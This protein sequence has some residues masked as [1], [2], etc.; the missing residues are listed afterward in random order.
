MKITVTES[1]IQKGARY[2]GGS[3]PI[4]LAI[5]EK[6]KLN[7]AHIAVAPTFVVFYRGGIHRLPTKAL[8]FIDIFDRGAEAKPFSFNLNVK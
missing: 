6:M 8:E 1:H 2:N 7:P 3:C 4:A 5:M